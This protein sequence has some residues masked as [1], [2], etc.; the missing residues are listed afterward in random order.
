MFEVLV[1]SSVMILGILCLRKLTMGKI[2]MKVRYALWLLVAVRLLMPVSVGTSPF[3]VMNLLPDFLQASGQQGSYVSPP[4]NGQEKSGVTEAG[5]SH[6]GQSKP[7]SE[8]MGLPDKQHLLGEE[9]GQIYNTKQN[10]LETEGAHPDALSGEGQKRTLQGSGLPASTILFL[11]WLFGFLAVGGYQLI[12]QLRF[13]RYLQKNRLEVPS[14]TFSGEWKKRLEKRGMKAY[15]VKGLPSPCLAGGHI[16][17][18]EQ[19]LSASQSL[20]HVLAHE[21]CH[22]LHLDGFWA[23]LRCLLVSVYWFDPFVWAAV[24]A[25][26]QD[27]ELACDEAAV[28]LLGESQRFA[29]GR[30]LLALLADKGNRKGYPGMF[31]MLEGGEGGM[32]E[33]ILALAER[34]K[35]RGIVTA[36]AVTVV[37]VLC[38]CAFTGAEQGETVSSEE[39]SIQVQTAQESGA[40]ENG[41]NGNEETDSAPVQNPAEDEDTAAATEQEAFEEALNYH[42]IMEG[43]DD[44]ELTLNR[45]IDY[46]AYYEYLQG[47][48]ENP[49]INGW[50]LLCE[51]EREGISLY[52]LYTEQ[53][54]FRGVKT[55][56]EV[57]GD[58]NTFDIKWYP[59]MANQNKENIRVLDRESNGLA[60]RFVWKLMAEESSTVEIWHLYSAY[61]YDTG[62]IDLKMLTE[63]ECIAWA[64]RYLSFSVNQETNMVSVICDGDMVLGMLNTFAYEGYEI[65][66]VQ[67]APSTLGF[68]LYSEA[69][70]EDY[71]W[72]PISSEAYGGDYRDG[73]EGIVVHLVPGL[74]L[75]G[76]DEIWIDQM[77]IIDVQVAEE[78]NGSGF[79]LQQPRIDADLEARN[80][81][82]QDELAKL[83]KWRDGNAS[84]DLEE[85][86]VNAEAGHH[87]VALTFVNPCPDYDRISDSYGERT[88][89]ITGEKR[90]HSGVDMAAPMGTDVLA[91]ADG[92]VYRTGFD[93]TDGNY[94]VLWHGESGQMTYYTHCKDILVSEGDRVSARDKIATV[95]QTGRATGPHLH[96]AVSYEG[97]WQ[98][99]VWDGR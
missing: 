23:F 19:T 40:E 17:I 41:Q 35:R 67:I 27:S 47:E 58:V 30:T 92:T 74:K 15:Q 66:G 70:D 51:N 59:S 86:L 78:E 90:M 79:R 95:G 9:T 37:L 89:P 84:G 76:S 36:I 50:Y 24:F 69:Y 8:E 88:N 32:R 25:A 53:F 39:E 75:K 20:S 38:G 98:E 49:M 42:G 31:P 83:Q 64:E 80:K 3:S 97:E 57:G 68:E 18:A 54:G 96:F 34:G 71:R 1:T 62:T 11:L 12:S 4:E 48:G 82:Q 72:L 22:A 45:K 29:Y 6:T 43:K 73:Y 2:S 94:V 60:R 65:E 77:Q 61:Q 16:Y 55:W 28:R 81:A 46:Q 44:S 52:G 56:M 5:L 13:I 10:V 91:V 7:E 14:D 33:R 63:E 26:R 21:Y 85:P 93:A 99:P 87:D